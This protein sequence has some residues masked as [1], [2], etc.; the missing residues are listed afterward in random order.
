MDGLGDFIKCKEIH[1]YQSLLVVKTNYALPFPQKALQQVSSLKNI[2]EISHAAKLLKFETQK[3]QML[4][5]DNHQLFLVFEDF[6]TSLDQLQP[7]DENDLWQIIDDIL[8]YL[9]D[10][11][12]L[13]HTHGDLQP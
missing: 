8:S 12:H 4:C 13:G 5:Y 11:S 10:L 9:Y 2:N 7:L 6:E 3:N 1:T